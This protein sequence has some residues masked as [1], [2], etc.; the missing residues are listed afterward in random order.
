[1]NVYLQFDSRF[2]RLCLWP[3]SWTFIFY[4]CLACTLIPA[5]FCICITTIKLNCMLRSLWTDVWP[6]LTQFYGVSIHASENKQLNYRNVSFNCQFS[7]HNNYHTTFA[8]LQSFV[9][10]TTVSKHTYLINFSQGWRLLDTQGVA[11]K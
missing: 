8:V 5:F 11:Q 1:M 9:S 6:L 4:N 10:V 3:E 7:S 2:I